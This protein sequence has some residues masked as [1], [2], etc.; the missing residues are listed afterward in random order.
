VK[1]FKYCPDLK[2]AKEVSTAWP[3]LNLQ[4]AN[5][6]ILHIDTAGCREKILFSRWQFHFSRF[7]HTWKGKEFSMKLTE[8]LSLFFQLRIAVQRPLSI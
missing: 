5:H 6:S 4:R 7:A 3:S 1:C 8:F 2:L